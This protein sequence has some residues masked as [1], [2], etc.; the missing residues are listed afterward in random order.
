M[1][2]TNNN[3]KRKYKCISV[4]LVYSTCL[5]L[6]LV[7]SN[8]INLSVATIS[9][10]VFAGKLSDLRLFLYTWPIK[11][12]LN[13]LPFCGHLSYLRCPQACGMTLSVSAPYIYSDSQPSAQERL[14]G[15]AK[16]GCLIWY[17]QR[18]RFLRVIDKVLLG[19][20]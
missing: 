2:F 18:I 15:K 12:F 1:S 5:N 6:L 16:G 19:H 7:L 13:I 14:E 8:S 9:C 4:L 10:S 11:G 20:C 3:K 17:S